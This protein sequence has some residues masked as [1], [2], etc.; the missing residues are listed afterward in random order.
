[1][2]SATDD[3]TEAGKPKAVGEMLRRPA[4]LWASCTR[5]LLVSA[6]K[7]AAHP[8]L[9]YRNIIPRRSHVTEAR[10]TVDR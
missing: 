5:N 9:Q 6:W 8:E 4:A 10:A 3:V 7:E 1:M 2:G